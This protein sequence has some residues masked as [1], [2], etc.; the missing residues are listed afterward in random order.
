M[1]AARIALKQGET[2][3]D[4]PAAL[5][6]DMFDNPAAGVLPLL[7]APAQPHA[8]SCVLRYLHGSYVVV[9]VH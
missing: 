7:N 3:P 4:W 9:E 1:D 6:S 5:P 2:A 8:S